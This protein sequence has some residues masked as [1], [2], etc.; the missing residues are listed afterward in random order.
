MSE[1]RWQDIQLLR[2]PKTI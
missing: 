1:C 2:T